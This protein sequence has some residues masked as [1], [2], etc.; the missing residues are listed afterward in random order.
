MNSE[1]LARYR[2]TACF[3][4]EQYNDNQ[5]NPRCGLGVLSFPLERCMHYAYTDEPDDDELEAES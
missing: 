5:N 4:C 2:S 3:P 1:C